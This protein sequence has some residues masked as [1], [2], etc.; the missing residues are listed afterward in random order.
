MLQ[1]PFTYTKFSDVSYYGE[2]IIC[3]SELSNLDTFSFSHV[4]KQTFVHKRR[5]I[6]CNLKTLH[7]FDL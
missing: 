1:A 3:D 7:N 2:Y 5:Y 4:N 6:I